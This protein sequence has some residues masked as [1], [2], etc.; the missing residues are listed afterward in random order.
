MPR[1]KK[2]AEEQQPSEATSAFTDTNDPSIGHNDTSDADI[3]K[4]GRAIIRKDVEIEEASDVLKSL[5]GERRNMV[6]AAKKQG[7]PKDALLRVIRDRK[8]ETDEVVAEERQYVRLMALFNMPIE[9]MELFPSE[10]PPQRAMGDAA[11]EQ[12]RF[13]AEDQGYRA[14]INGHLIDTNPHHQ[15]ED[16]EEWAAFGSGWHRG[17]AHLARGLAPRKRGRPAASAEEDADDRTELE[18][19]ESAYREKGVSTLSS[20]MP[21]DPA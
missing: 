13:D 2:N 4:V 8:R 21:A 11:R 3:L 5:V 16:S 14:G 6:K 19:N 12:A 1:G 18:R 20:D 9:Q 15:T 17:Q 7:M 10:S